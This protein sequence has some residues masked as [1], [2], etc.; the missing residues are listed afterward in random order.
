MDKDVVMEKDIVIIG[1]GPGGYVA[2]IRAAQ[3]GA[4]VSLIEKAELGGTCLNRGCIP[5]KVLYRNAEILNTLKN[6][7]EFGIMVDSYSINVEEIQSRKNTIVDQLVSGVEKLLN[8]NNIE[9]ILGSAS[10]KDKN[11]VVIFLIN[12]EIREITTKNI[13]IA[14][15]S[16]PSIPNIPGITLPGVFTSES[17]LKF[18]EVPN[19][20]A[21]IG[22]GVIGME[23]AGIFNALGSKVTVIEFLPSILAPVDSDLTK[24]LSLSLKRKGIDINTNTKVISIEKQNEELIVKAEG[25]SGEIIFKADNVLISVGRTPMTLGLNIEGLGIELNRRAIKIDKNYE[26]N[27]PNIY[28][29][30]DVNGKSMLAH[31]AT[32]QGKKVAERIMGYIG[33]HSME[34]VPSCIFV[35]PEIACVGITENEAKESGIEYK[36]SK[37]LFGANGKALALGEGEGMVK[38]IATLDNTIIGVHIMGPHASDLIHEG[39]LAINNNMKVDN[40]AS[41]IH[42]HPTL[43]EAFEEAVLGLKGEAIHSVPTKKR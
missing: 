4:R 16:I 32:H 7:K 31:A 20:L 36:T 14:T 8:A 40:I 41:M 29:I 9:I 25:K 19:N 11:T 21:V 39:N 42:A 17:I 22:G 13:I 24:R 34:I 38:V 30:G 3:L 23:F 12:G 1:G 35:F 26:T 27:I 37:F 10:I 15:G 33:L 6:I 18:K 28:A 2:A 43:S 5:T